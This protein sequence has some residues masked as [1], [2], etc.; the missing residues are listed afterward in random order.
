MNELKKLSEE[1]LSKD[2]NS[3]LITSVSQLYPQLDRQVLE[4]ASVNLPEPQ[5]VSTM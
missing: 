3:V 1:T 5:T 4:D 2:E